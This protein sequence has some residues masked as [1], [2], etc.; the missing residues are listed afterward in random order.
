[1]IVLAVVAT[2]FLPSPA[3]AG[4]V[5]RDPPGYNGIKKAPKTKPPVFPTAALSNTGTF[6]N[7]VVD[8]AGTAHIVWNEGRGNADDATI[9]CRLKRGATSCDARRTLV[10]N[11]S[12]GPGD[13]PLFNTD[14]GG[15]RIVRVGDQLVV[16]SKRYPTIGEKPDGASSSTVVGWVSNDGGSSWSNAQI[17][18]KWNLGQLAVTGPSDDPTIVNLGHDPLCGG[19]CVTAYRSGVYAASQGLL[20]TDP[21]SNYDATLAN[22]GA[23]VVGAFSDLNPRIWLRRWNRM[24]PVTDPGSWSTSAPIPG[25]EPDLA[26]GPGG[27][28]LMHRPGFSGAYQVRPLTV[29]AGDRMVPGA[30]QPISKAA[31]ARFGRLAEDASGRLLA[32]WQQEGS[33]VQLRTSSA[34]AGG[35]APAQRL[36]GG[37]GNGQIENFRN[38]RKKNNE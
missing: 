19:M 37:E 22:D 10:W 7:L 11:K 5:Y 15:P 30:A 3:S 17:L 21:N 34:G 23:A 16:L 26:G 24:G 31:G 4:P 32:A 2:A 33:G 6:P 38:Y 14:D 36:I 28:F 18:G 20:N 27:A 29:G 1:L 12:Y 35:F 13:G 8:E 9:Y 25:D